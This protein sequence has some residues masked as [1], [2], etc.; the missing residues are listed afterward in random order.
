MNSV[1]TESSKL[2]HHPEWT[3][4]FNKTTVTWTT[5]EPAGLGVKDVAMARVCDRLAVKYEEV[6]VAKGCGGYGK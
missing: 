2:R 6:D 4:M 3:N 1:A 5:H